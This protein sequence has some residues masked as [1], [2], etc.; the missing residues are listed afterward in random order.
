MKILIVDDSKAMRMIV[1]RTLRQAGFGSHELIEA[2]DGA[3]ALEQ[4][5]VHRPDLVMCDWNM[6]D[7]SGIEVL[8]TLTDQGNRVP[9]GFV[10][11][12]VIE[13]LHQQAVRL[14]ARFFITKPFTP[15]AFE[16][17]LAPLLG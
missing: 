14:G 2:G 10:T 11:S 6:P 12:E 3:A 15:E 7:V 8:Q 4:I 16:A 17:A 5:K 1:M 13:D 9:F